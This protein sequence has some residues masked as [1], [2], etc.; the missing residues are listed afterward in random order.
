MAKKICFNLNYL[1]AVIFILICYGFFHFSFNQKI[2]ELIE[3]TNKDINSEEYCNDRGCNDKGC[4]NNGCY[5]NQN[6]I[7][8]RPDYRKLKS[9]DRVFNPLE[10]PFQSTPYYNKFLV[11]IIYSITWDIRMW[12]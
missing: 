1:Y 12:T 7:S 2:N 4:N 6:I 5:D 10:Y 8:V 3:R 9:L 11:S